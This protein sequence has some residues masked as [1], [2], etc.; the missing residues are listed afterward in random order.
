MKA[1]VVGAGILG[2][3]MAFELVNAAWSVALFDQQ[4]SMEMHNCS[5]VA[6]GLLTPMTEL[7]KC[8][9]VIFDLG[10]VALLHHWPNIVGAL[11]A[12]EYF[13]CRGSLVVSHPNDFSELQRFTHIIRDKLQDKTQCQ[14]LNQTEIL[15][16][17]PELAK[18]GSAFYFTKEGCLDNTVI[19]EKLAHYLKNASVQFY[20]GEKVLNVMPSKII[21]QRDTYQFDVVFDCRG[22]SAKAIFSDLRGVRGEVILLHA[23][24]VNITRPVRLLSPKHYLYIVPR[25]HHHYM[26]GASEIE[27]EDESNIS[28]RTALEL[29]SSACYLHS[30]FLEARIIKTMTHLR[31]TLANHLPKIKYTDGLVAINGLYR[32]GFLVAPSLVKDAMQYIQHGVASVIYSNLW[33]KIDANNFI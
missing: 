10:S 21:T 6:A 26:L 20:L 23:P 12:T 18:W 19:L 3:L 5:A 1:G 32:H 15:A 13:Q 27:S 14:I 17:E 7:E 31:P 11:D 30:G 22:L 2:R 29:L 16:L 28:V 25:K 9:E 24:D 4:A 33:E 8:G